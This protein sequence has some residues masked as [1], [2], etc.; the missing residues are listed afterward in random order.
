MVAYLPI[1]FNWQNGGGYGNANDGLAITIDGVGPLSCSQVPAVATQDLQ[2]RK[3]TPRECERLQAF[4]RRCEPTEP[5]AWQDDAG[6]WWTADYTLVP[7][8]KKLAAD[9][10]RYKAL[11]NS[12]CVNVMRWIGQQI[13]FA[14][15]QFASNEVLAEPADIQDAIEAGLWPEEEDLFA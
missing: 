5:G 2:V 14:H 7:Q 3:L 1:A 10:P 12:M 11:G 6:R 15:H 13:D 9:G 4:Q 8:G